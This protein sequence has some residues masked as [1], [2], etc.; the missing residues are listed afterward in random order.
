MARARVRV[1][2]QAR[3]ASFTKGKHTAAHAHGVVSVNASVYGPPLA[4]L[5]PRGPGGPGLPCPSSACHGQAAVPCFA[6]HAVPISHLPTIYTLATAPGSPEDDEV[7]ASAPD[8]DPSYY[9]SLSLPE[10]SSD[11]MRLTPD[12]QM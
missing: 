1:P 12:G 3:R 2:V 9:R 5:P 7:D 11:R 8:L 6:S 10:S 4:P